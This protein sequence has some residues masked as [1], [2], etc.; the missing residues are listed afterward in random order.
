M[1]RN[2]ELWVQCGEKLFNNGSSTS[3]N[4]N[5]KGPWQNSCLSPQN[6][7]IDFSSCE[8]YKSYTFSLIFIG[9]VGVG[10]VNL[11]YF[12]SPSFFPS[13]LLYIKL[14]KIIKKKVMT[15]YLFSGM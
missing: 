6:H 11:E 10:V 12:L 1:P 14:F 3:T 8:V 7:T 9:V 4:K 15:L 13:P 2:K 5:M